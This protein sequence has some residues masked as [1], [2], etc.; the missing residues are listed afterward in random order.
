[1]LLGC[2]NNLVDNKQLTAHTLCLQHLFLP[3]PL[4]VLLLLFSDALQYAA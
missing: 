2:R 4:S 3:Q 1:M